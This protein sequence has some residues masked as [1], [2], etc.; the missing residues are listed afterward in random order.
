MQKFL[1]AST[2]VM[3]GALIVGDL[4][5]HGGTYR[6]PG[7]TV[8]P[9]A[10]GEGAIGGAPPPSGFPGTGA[11]PTPGTGAGPL[12]PATGPG[13]GP[14]AGG[15]DAAPVTGVDLTTDLSQWSFW[16]EFNK[17]GFLNLRKALDEQV[18]TGEIGYWL[19]DGMKSQA[20]TSVRPSRTQIEEDIVPALLESLEQET[21][22][23]I[24]TGCLI[25]L[26]K[27]GDRVDESGTSQFQETFTRFLAHA[28]QEIRE[29]AAIALG[30]LANPSSLDL[31]EALVFNRELGQRAVASNEVDLRTRAYAAYGLGLVGAR[32]DDPGVRERIVA[33]LLE[34]LPMS[35]GLSTP[36]VGVAVVSSMGLV[37]LA[38]VPAPLEADSAVT[39]IPQQIEALLAYFDNP[40]HDRFVRA[41]VPT[42]VGRLFTAFEASASDEDG[43]QLK[44]QLAP[45]LLLPLDPKRGR[46]LES[47]VRMASA[48][49]LGLIG[50]ADD[51]DLDGEIR[52]A[53]IGAADDPLRQ[54][55]KFALIGLA[56]SA[57]RP[58]QDEV[59]SAR[60]RSETVDYL[61]RNMERGRSGVERWAG[62]AAGVY[63]FQL[64]ASG[65]SAPSA[66][67]SSLCKQLQQAKS[68][69]DIGA[70]SVAAGLFGNKQ[71]VE[72]LLGR[73]ETTTEDEARGYVALA[74]GLLDDRRAIEPI[75]AVVQQSEYRPALLKQAATALGLLGDREASRSLVAML[76]EAQGLATQAAL[77]SALGQIGDRDSIDLLVEMLGDATLTDTA[78]GFAAVALG[79]IAEKELFPW[80]EKLSR[81]VNYRSAT[82]TLNS[83]AGTGVLNLL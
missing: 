69:D 8:P 80:N 76:G 18:V 19:G 20:R 9:G 35:H 5:A 27:I 23:D 50:D 73:L 33:A 11:S 41:H 3:G 7:D 15:S 36:D 6:G 75:Q 68:M 66:L 42:A 82:P 13:G 30:I 56:K 67:Y 14:L 28:N 49:A 24:V 12:G 2:L 45:A 77:A 71:L 26:A 25:A 60:G 79:L 61:I 34:A 32:N 31:L 81:D 51:E 48:L 52:D 37:P 53:L 21:N 59:Q 63:A 44:A 22:K 1:L 39:T 64:N 70:F 46:Y 4:G 47:E 74:L 54:V 62:I 83:T 72:D 58:G 29:T 55:R 43:A 17:D 10:G 40:R 38:P 78:R 57:A 16:W 65:E